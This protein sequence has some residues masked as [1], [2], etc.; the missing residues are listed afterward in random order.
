ML[1]CCQLVQLPLWKLQERET[2]KYSAALPH[3]NLLLCFATR[4]SC[5]I[6]KY[7][8]LRSDSVDM[9]IFSANATE[10]PDFI[11]DNNVTTSCG[12]LLAAVVNSNGRNCHVFIMYSI[13]G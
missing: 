6:P 5:S 8:F 2:S 1:S 10:L 4:H 12:H 3:K 13:L 11:S 9:A 7:M